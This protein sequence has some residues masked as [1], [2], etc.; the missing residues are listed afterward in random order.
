MRSF[1]FVIALQ[2]SGCG[3]AEN[4]ATNAAGDEGETAEQKALETVS[5]VQHAMLVPDASALPPCDEASEGLLVYVKSDAAFQACAA[6]A[7]GAIDLKG[8]DGK[9]G[10]KGEDGEDG[11]DGID[12]SSTV[13]LDPIT[14]RRWLA[15]ISGTWLAAQSACSGAYALPGKDELLDAAFHGLYNGL[16]N[17][18]SAWAA[19]DES[20]GAPAGNTSRVVIDANPEINLLGK[21]NTIGVYCVEAAD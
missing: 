17:Y 15:A 20:P 2:I 14:G 12:S 4:A 21:T 8:K 3:T 5:G 13:W 16:N 7:W 9:D 18:T 1:Y 10:V 6:G 19:E 11:E